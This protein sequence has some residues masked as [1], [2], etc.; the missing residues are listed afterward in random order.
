MAA[1]SPSILMRRVIDLSA[2]ELL[3]LV[4]SALTE[5]S[6]PSE[7]PIVAGAPTDPLTV[8]QACALAQCSPKTI[9]R[10]CADGRLEGAVKPPGLDG[11][12]IPLA[13]LEAWLKRGRAPTR[14]VELDNDAQAE[15]IAARIQRRG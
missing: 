13:S 9:R 3:D 10:A 5:R 6:R 8:A 2:A 11:W 12:R 1:P 4:R 14:P 15:Q 7:T